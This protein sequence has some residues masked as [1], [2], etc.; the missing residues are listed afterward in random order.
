MDSV[1]EIIRFYNTSPLSVGRML[2]R[3][4]FMTGTPG[5]WRVD[6]SDVPLSAAVA[7][8][9]EKVILSRMNERGVKEALYIFIFHAHRAS[10]PARRWR[11]VSWLTT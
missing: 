4:I 3:N 5:G 7:G 9:K 2:E 6:V 8:S 11:A 1:Q 10:G